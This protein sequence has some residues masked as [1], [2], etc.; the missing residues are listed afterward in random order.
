MMDTEIIHA[1]PHGLANS[2]SYSIACITD[3]VNGYLVTAVDI[4]LLP[5]SCFKTNLSVIHVTAH[6][7]NLPAHSEDDEERG[8]W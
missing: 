3:A 2:W 5:T 4:C 6:G 1:S 7:G 8:T